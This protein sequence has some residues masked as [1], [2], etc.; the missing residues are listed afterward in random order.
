MP[1]AYSAMIESYIRM[2]IK[3]DYILPIVHCVVEFLAYLILEINL[4]FS[5]TI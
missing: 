5:N 2:A 3:S 4:V 1:Y